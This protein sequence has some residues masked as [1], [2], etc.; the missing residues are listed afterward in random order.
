MPGVS[1]T[2][3]LVP[4]GHSKPIGKY[5]PGVRVALPCGGAMIFISGQV[6]SDSAGNLLGGNDA[7]SQAEAVFCQLRAVLRECGADLGNLVSVTIFLTDMRDLTA[8]S[9]VRNRFLGDPPPASTL[10]QVSQLAEPGRLV[11]I[12]GIAMAG[13]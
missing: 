11:E 3:G 7:A 1:G 12:N 10:V 13:W 6:A 8:V 2:E 5:S 9:E 4:E